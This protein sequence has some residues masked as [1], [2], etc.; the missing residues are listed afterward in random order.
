MSSYAN[1]TV[2][3]KNPIK[4][5]LQKTRLKQSLSGLKYNQINEKTSLKI[6][7]WGGGSGELC[8][9]LV[10]KFPAA[11]IWCYEPVEKMREEAKSNLENLPSVKIIGDVSDLPHSAFDV[12]F[13][14]EVFEHLPEQETEA[15]IDNISKLLKPSGYACIG[16][17]NEIYISALIKGLFRM[18]RRYGSFDAKW[19]NLIAATMGNPPTDRPVSQIEGLAYYHPHMGFDFRLFEKD[20]SK[21]LKIEKIWGSPM[22]GLPAILNFEVYFLCSHKK[23]I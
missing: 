18:T 19:T 9:L 8:K 7:D 1:I 14:L 6:I 15:A 17:P 10:E 4:R 13:C 12:I 3:D 20:V 23:E 2:N 22:T 5:W 21:K 11:Q 16:V